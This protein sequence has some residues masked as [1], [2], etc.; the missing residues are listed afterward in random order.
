MMRRIIAWSMQLRLLMVA[1]AAVLL[2]FGVTELRQMP[3]DVLPEFS[4][5]RV[6][7]QT[8][9]L[10]LS[11]N[12]VEAMLTVPLEADMLNGAP[13]VKHIR[14]ESIP[15]LSSIVLEFE[16]GT[17]LLVSR[18]MTHERMSE[19]YALPGVSKPPVMLQPI[20]STS[21]LL[22][23]GVNSDTHS[24]IDLSVLARWTIVPRLMGVA[25]VANVS[26][27]GNRGKQ[28]QVHVDP[29]KLHAAGVTLHQ[30]I[31][32]SGNALWASPLTFLTASSPGTGGWL[33][34]PNQRLG[35]QHIQPISEPADLAKV[36]VEGSYLALADVATVV[37]DHQPL[38]GDA[39]VEDNAA[40]MLVVEKLPWASTVDVTRGVEAAVD[41][42]QLGLPGVRMDTTLFRPATYLELAEEHLSRTLL[43]AFA[44]VAVA[45]FGLL[46][47]W[48]VALIST[49]AV[50]VSA[51]AAGTVLYLHGMNLNM[52]LIAGLIVALGAIIDDAIID[53]QNVA[54][55][56]RDARTADKS[57][58][59][60][61]FEAALA[62][63]SPILYATL[64]SLLVIVPI[65]L[66][67]GV[68]GALTQPIA[69]AYASALLASMA[70]AL[71]ITPALCLL[72]LRDAPLP[73][74]ESPIVTALHGAFDGLLARSAGAAGS[75]VLVAVG[76]A[77]A[78]LLAILIAFPVSEESLLPQFRE[79]DILVEME[80]P[81]GTSDVEM[82]RIV[83]R[84]SRE[85]R[86]IPGV[87]NVSAHVGRA[88]MSDRVTDVDSSEL[89]VSIDRTADYDRTLA[90]IQE[91]VVGY[92][93][94][95]ID[96]DTY[97]TERLRD[98]AEIDDDF[99]V[100]V[101]GEDFDT[102]ARKAEEVRQ[103]LDRIDGV[104]D[105]KVE[106]ESVQP[107][108]EI[109]VDMERSNQYGLK[110]GDVRRAATTLLSGIEVG[111]LFE[112]QKIFE[113]VVWGSP[114]VRRNL[115][116]IENL[117]IDTPARPGQ[118]IGDQVPLK[119]VADLR[120][121][122]APRVIHRE[123]VARHLDV[124]S[125]VRGRSAAAVAAE[126]DAQIRSG[127][128]F[129]LEFRAEVQGRYEERI[130][131]ANQV[132]AFAVA[133]AIA[134]FLL[135]QA[136]FGSWGLAGLFLLILPVAGLGGVLLGL[137]GG[138][139]VSLG[140]ILGFLAV[141]TLAVRNGL[142]LVW[143]YRQLEK[144]LGE[145]TSRE[146]VL[147]GTRERFVPI[148]MTAI[149]TALAFLPFAFS[150][151][152]AGHEMLRPMAVVVLGGLVTS[153]LVTLLV[154]PSLYLRFGAGAEPA[155]LVEE[156]PP[157]LVA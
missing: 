35:I 65:Y 121:V 53:V 157:R 138:L 143:H 3:L 7:I 73:E 117:L 134:I 145:G 55:R 74:R 12:E 107:T 50:L 149:V 91:A 62:M 68:W 88:I 49:L 79:R 152:L 36:T 135:L 123:S 9:A 124:V 128:E 13:W 51:C 78:A 86:S 54:R 80:G 32:T 11:A 94:L 43:V 106:Y 147:R 115:S 69:S 21:R 66:V 24:L 139:G 46:F 17:D 34:T 16:P 140:A 20:S 48:R 42:L 144:E 45:L 105:P 44:L 67:E 10:G 76:A 93:G 136:A 2:F 95:D 132:R 100:R 59:V 150:A 52:M 57:A 27:W 28:L 1:A 156:E 118:A 110:P 58:A 114:G 5:P 119:E 72:L 4:L 112:E 98:E 141:L 126:A 92:P 47:H 70:V 109:R 60:V 127:V 29:V 87:R 125:Q 89:W 81:P 31:E 104:V 103:V 41:S 26:I 8:E 71:T 131:A 39:V 61:I 142:T 113:V 102:L 40:L 64:I 84:A 38:I 101:Y 116:D 18:Q 90:A 82:A 23:I 15:G 111:S 155:V 77:G 151:G 133:A 122:S 130:A 108:L 6:E 146:I 63:R 14:S 56:L 153:T 83:S 137:V 25:G 19:V 22:K 154:V 85:L 148:A 97:M 99:V 33:E 30:V 96:V 129:P 120:I 75:G 37:E